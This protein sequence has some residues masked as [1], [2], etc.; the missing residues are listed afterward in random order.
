MQPLQIN[1][2]LRV[3]N[4]LDFLIPEKDFLTWVQF[5]G[6]EENPEVNRL[7]DQVKGI[8]NISKNALKEQ[9]G[10][11]GKKPG[12]KA[13][14]VKEDDVLKRNID[15]DLYQKIKMAKQRKS[16][17]DMSRN[18][19]EEYEQSPIV[20]KEIFEEKTEEDEEEIVSKQISM[21]NPDNK[22]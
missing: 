4:E 3:L 15:A 1:N 12:K 22:A 14:P 2:K 13:P 6:L 8:T 20:T 7:L 10:R 5:N 11:E 16:S 18:Y 17:M 9:N 21:I 19:E